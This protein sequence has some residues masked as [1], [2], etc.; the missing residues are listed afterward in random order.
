MSGN[1]VESIQAKAQEVAKEDFDKAKALVSNATRS[2]SFSEQLKS[3][4]IRQFEVEMESIT[5]STVLSSGFLLLVAV[6]YRQATLPPNPRAN[7][8]IQVDPGIGKLI[9]FDIGTAMAKFYSPFILAHF[10]LE[11]YS[12]WSNKGPSST[13]TN[14]CPLAD[15][16]TVQNI[17][18]AHKLALPSVF[19]LLLILISS[20]TRSAC[21]RQLGRMFTWE[22]SILDGHKLITSGPYRFVRHPSYTSLLCIATGYI[23]FIS[24]PG[25]FAWECFMKSPVL[26]SSFTTKNAFGMLYRIG[27]IILYG[28][29]LIFLIRRSFTEDEMLKREFGKEW[30]EWARNVRWNVIPYVL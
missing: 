8:K 4:E 20:I 3:N 9:P 11:I 22:T 25:T 10:G 1:Y 16:V 15:Q 26:S 5:S 23:W 24:T 2:G 21:H 14:I 29:S 19:P 27:Y 12:L 30:E 18:P 28:D 7:E 17:H 6:C 13:I